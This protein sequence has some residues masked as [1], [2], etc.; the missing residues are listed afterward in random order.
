LSE[1]FFLIDE[2]KKNF[3]ESGGNDVKGRYWTV[4]TVE[5][6]SRIE[7][8]YCVQVPDLNCFTLADNILTHNCGFV[9]TKDVNIDLAAP[10]AWAMD[11]LMLGVGIGFDAKGAGNI[12]IKQPKETKV[13]YEIPDSREGW[14]ESVKL[15]LNSYHGRNDVEF[16]Y[17]LIRPFGAPI[18]GF[19][20]Q[21]SG[22]QPL[23]ELHENIRNTL[24]NLVGEAI[25][26]VAIV[27]IMN[28]I[29]KC[30]VAGNVRR[31]AELGIGEIDDKEYVEMKDPEKFGEELADRRWASN[32]SVFASNDS[33][34]GLITGNIV[35]NGEP[36]LIFLDNARHYGRIKDGWVPFES[37]KYDDV[38]GFNPCVEQGL[39]NYELCCLVETFPANHDSPEEY[40]ETLKF[41]YLYSKSVTLVPTHD[42]KTNAVMMRN[43]RIGCSMSGIQQAFKKFG[44]S[45]FLNDFCDQGYETIRSWDRIYSRWLGVPR[46]IKMTTVKPS[47]TVSILAGATPGIHFTHDEYYY[48]TVRC[49]ASSP[50]IPKLRKAKY[51]IEYS[52]TDRKLL[53]KAM[54]MAGVEEFERNW[55]KDYLDIDSTKSFGAT[56]GVVFD[57]FAQSGGTVVVYFP[58]KEKNFTKSKF[59]V[60]V[61]EQVMSIREMQHYWSDNGVSCTI[62]FNKQEAEDLKR[63]IEFSAPYVKSLSFLPL[64]DHKYEQAPYQEIDEET[65]KKYSK[66]LKSVDFSESKEADI[67]GSKFCDGDQCEWS[68]DMQ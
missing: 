16:S 51:R 25:T 62:T 44:H 68:P 39:E 26:S 40:L 45:S 66:S 48:R 34:F 13:L 6:T 29:G 20:G 61:W 28:F 12:I 9:S 32:N 43:R 24:D 17:D 5:K 35:R 31:S 33:D 30:V 15:L 37:E 22:P 4:E 58:I 38:Q 54:K 55:W 60:S 2:H 7:T 27:D 23:I 11:M 59:D 10:F 14:V 63:V 42:E 21:S 65:Y 67:S 46:S 18:K 52:S 3:V 56:K 49:S 41:A 36:G 1:K 8:V 19:G 47:G 57:L 53:K 50:L 64:T